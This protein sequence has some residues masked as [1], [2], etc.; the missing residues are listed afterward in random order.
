MHIN[1]PLTLEGKRSEY[2][3]GKLIDKFKITFKILLISSTVKKDVNVLYT[4][5]LFKRMRQRASKPGSSLQVQ[6]YLIV[7]SVEEFDGPEPLI[8]E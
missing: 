8:L 3:E 2:F 6:S 5:A 7:E 1:L 4:F